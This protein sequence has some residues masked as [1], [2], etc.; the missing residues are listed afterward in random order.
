MPITRRQFERGIDAEIEDCMVKVHSLLGQSKDDA[1]TAE[2]IYEKLI[3]E[4]VET[5]DYY[6]PVRLAL[7]ALVRENKADQKSIRGTYYY[8]YGE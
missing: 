3:G 5:L 6:H 7:D 1:F 2:E 8:C 4:K